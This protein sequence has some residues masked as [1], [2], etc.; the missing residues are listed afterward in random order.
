[1]E[2]LNELAG[3]SLGGMFTALFKQ[4][5][6]ATSDPIEKFEVEPAAGGSRMVITFKEP[7]R[8]WINTPQPPG[9]T[10]LRFEKKV[11]CTVK[12]NEMQFESGLQLALI[13]DTFPF[14]G[15]RK[16]VKP[17]FQYD[18][19]EKAII[20]TAKDESTGISK[21]RKRPVAEALAIWGKPEVIKTAVAD[22]KFLI[23]KK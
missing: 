7:L 5:E 19:K 18:A 12:N 8:V 21:S 9:G 6:L 3:G 10:I 16:G 17:S 20:S 22:E 23:A 4:V 13:S 1:M 2:K 14:R 15:F 11:I